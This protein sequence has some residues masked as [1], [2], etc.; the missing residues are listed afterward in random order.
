MTFAKV[1]MIAT[2]CAAGLF[3]TTARAAAGPGSGWYAGADLGRMEYKFDNGFD[4]SDNAFGVH[5]G[6][7][8]SRYFA[9]EAGYADLGSY[10][11]SVACPT[12]TLCVPEDYP[13]Y[14]EVSS[15]RIELNVLGI[16]PLG[17]R[18]EAYAKAGYARTEFDVFVREGIHDGSSDSI[19]SSDPNYGIGLRLNFDAPWSL[20]LQWERTPD[21]ND[22]DADLNALWLGAEYRFGG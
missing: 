14:T 7:R 18:L 11:F 21:M 10:D 12:G 3:T 4:A 22:S 8:F 19:R 20:R 17:E 15:Q 2:I 5:G 9:I 13:I 6:Y 16:L 1:S